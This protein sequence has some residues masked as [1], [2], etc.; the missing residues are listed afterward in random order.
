MQQDR[1]L[2]CISVTNMSVLQ[3]RSLLNIETQAPNR[4]EDPVERVFSQSI[5]RSEA[6]DVFLWREVDAGRMYW[7]LAVF[8]GD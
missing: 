5:S 1:H 3:W 7:E 8:G 6:F 4:L 2:A